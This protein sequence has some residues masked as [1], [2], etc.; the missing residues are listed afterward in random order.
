MKLDVSGIE[1]DQVQVF[2]RLTSQSANAKAYYSL[3]NGVHH[4]HCLS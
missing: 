4:N 3:D 1:L 2:I